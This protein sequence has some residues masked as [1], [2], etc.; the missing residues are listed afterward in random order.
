VTIDNGTV[1]EGQSSRESGATI[2]MMDSSG[3]FDYHLTRKLLDLCR[4][5]EIQHQRD[6][7]RHYRCDSASAVEAGNDTRTALICF[8]IDA[9]HGYERTHLNALRS[10]AELT[11]L[12]LQSEPVFMKDKSKLVQ[13]GE[14]SKQVDSFLENK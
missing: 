9:S 8:G 11:G 10:L 12:Y 13:F 6:L 2:A 7:F 3:P 1:A 4:E 5:H 14:F